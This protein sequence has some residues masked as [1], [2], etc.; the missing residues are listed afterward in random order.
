VRRFVEISRTVVRSLEPTQHPQA[1]L[2]PATEDDRLT[3]DL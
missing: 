2:P 3:I 1:A